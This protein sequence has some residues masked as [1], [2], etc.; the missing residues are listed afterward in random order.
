MTVTLHAALVDEIIS[1][2]GEHFSGAPL[3]A[4]DA[5]TF[6][7]QNG[8]MLQARF[9]SAEEY[10]IQWRFG[11][12]ELRIDTAPLHPDLASFPNHRHGADGSVHS[13]DLTHPGQPP[14]DNLM[15]VLNVILRDPLLRPPG[16][17]P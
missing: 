6:Y 16:N 12:A 11:E 2:F 14:R 15:A 17:I 9:A 8:L 4:H 7:F 10:S 5:V 1:H 3:I 13:D